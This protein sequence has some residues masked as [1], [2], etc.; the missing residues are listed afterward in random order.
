[1][2]EQFSYIT[3]ARINDVEDGVKILLTANNRQKTYVHAQAVAGMN[4]RIA[5]TY[6][7]DENVCKICGLLHDIAAVIKPDDMT[8]YAVKNGWHIDEAEMK[9]PFLLHQRVSRQ[10]AEEGFKITD[11]RVLSAVECHTTLKAEPSEYDM[12]LFIADK[13][14]WDQDGAPP[15]LAVVEGALGRSLAAAA[16]AYMDYIVKHKMILYPHK[17]FEDGMEY[18]AASV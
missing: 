17:W 1:M 5:A 16:Y 3:N 10:I 6:G 12:A 4:V 15:F 14:A 7:L 2:L 8:A 9:Y 13:L 11:L 18:L